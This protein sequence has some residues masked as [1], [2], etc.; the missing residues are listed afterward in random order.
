MDHNWISNISQR[1]AA[2]SV[3]YQNDNVTVDANVI[4][5]KYFTSTQV[6]NAGVL[7]ESCGGF[8]P[9]R[10]DV[11]GNTIVLHSRFRRA[12]SSPARSTSIS[13]NVIR[14]DPATSAGTSAKGIYVNTSAAMKTVTIADNRIDNPYGPGINVEAGQATIGGALVIDRNVIRVDHA[15][16][17]RTAAIKVNTTGP[18]WGR[19]ALG[20]GPATEMA[21]TT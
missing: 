13:R 11:N 9:R 20:A 5:H 21:R 8:Q 4:D 1:Y 3:R 14:W 7:V 19:G 2:I 16:H 18:P 10:V 6:D 17:A 12:S 15:P